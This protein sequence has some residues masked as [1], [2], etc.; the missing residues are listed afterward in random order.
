MPNARRV[1]YSSY[2]VP[3]ETE[4]SETDIIHEKLDTTTNIKR[5]A[6]KGN[7]E[8]AADQTS[9]P[10]NNAWTSFFAPNEYWD[11]LDNTYDEWE[12]L[13]EGW[14]GTLLITN[15]SP[16]DLRT[17][18]SINID[19]IYI[20]NTGSHNT[21]TLNLHAPTPAVRHDILIPPGAA[22]SMRVADIHTTDRI[23]VDT[24]DGSTTIEYVIAKTS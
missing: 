14:D 8:I 11:T 22:V 2:V 9:S 5:L 10:G 18:A 20:K 12:D 15:G 4:I 13:Y 3:I 23:K 16:T 6:G 19:F 17:G 24:I 1:I 7:V 21:A